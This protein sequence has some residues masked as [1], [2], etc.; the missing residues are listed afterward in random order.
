MVCVGGG[1]RVC[2]QGMCVGMCNEYVCVCYDRMRRKYIHVY[3]LT[4]FP[5]HTHTHAHAHTH[6][7]TPVPSVELLAGLTPNA[8]V[9]GCYDSISKGYNIL[10][11]RV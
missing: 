9:H 11:W 10:E 4:P 5:L 8:C 7:H 6:T 1:V 2:V 3:Y